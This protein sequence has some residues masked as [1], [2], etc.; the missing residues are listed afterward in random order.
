[1]GAGELMLEDNLWSVKFGKSSELEQERKK[2]NCL[3]CF[4]SDIYI[5]N[6]LSCM[7]SFCSSTFSKAAAVAFFVTVADVGL[8]ASLNV[9]FFHCITWISKPFNARDWSNMQ[10]TV[11][12]LANK[13][14]IW[15]LEIIRSGL[16]MKDVMCLYFDQFLIIC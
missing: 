9:W 8:Y 11:Y 3:F 1:M 13:I 4:C 5:D 6:L 7:P 2:I 16:N 15:S 12:L 14:E 10:T